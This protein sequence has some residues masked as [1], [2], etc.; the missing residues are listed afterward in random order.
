MEFEP[1]LGL[2]ML[3]FRTVTIAAG[4]IAVAHFPAFDAAENLPAQGFGAALLDGAHG[5]VVRRQQAFSV[6]LPVGPAINAENL[7]QF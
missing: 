2:L 3:A 5:L 6:L 4:V 7:G 1:I